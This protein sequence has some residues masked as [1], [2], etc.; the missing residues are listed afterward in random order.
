MIFQSNMRNLVSFVKI[1]L[2]MTGGQVGFFQG[3]IRKLNDDFRTL[4]PT[5]IPCVPRLLNRMYDSVRSFYNPFCLFN[6]SF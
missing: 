2:Y 4:R 1:G 6:F 5:V 3:D